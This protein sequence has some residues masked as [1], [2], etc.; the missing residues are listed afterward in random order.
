MDNNWTIYM[1][2]NKVNGKKYIGITSKD[3]KERWGSKGSK[4]RSSYFSNA[5]KK[6]GWDSFQHLIIFSGLTEEAAKY[7]EPLLIKAFNTKA[8]NGYNIADGG[9]GAPGVHLSDETKKKMSIAS[10]LKWSDFEFAQKMTEIRN[11]PN[12]AYQSEGF[13]KK[14][15]SLVKG[16]NNPNYNHKWSDEQKESLRI[17]Q[18]S[19]PMYKN[20]TNPNAKRIRCIETGE[21]FECMKFAQERFGLKTTGSFTAAIKKNKTAAGFHWEYV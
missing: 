11:D 6:Y 7:L 18:K 21:I 10:K 16:E 15:S 20:E 17:K 12:G 14:I 1:H 5:S 19:N 8:P 13:K 9:S 2:I 3:P 4:Y